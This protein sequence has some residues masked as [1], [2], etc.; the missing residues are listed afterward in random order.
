M[1]SESKF[2]G[3]LAYDE[4]SVAGNM[5]WGVFE[6]KPFTED[7]VDIEIT[8]SGICGSDIHTLRSGWG[9]TMYPCVVGHE[10][11]G[12]AV[13]VGSKAQQERGIK[14]GDRVGVGA[15]SGSCLK[16]ECAMCSSNEEPRCLHRVDTY[17]SIYPDGSKSYGGYANYNR[18]PGHFVVKIP[19]E[20][21]SADA[22]PMLCGGITVYSPLKKNGCGSTA[23][24]I[25]IVGIGGL[26]HFGLLFAKALG[27]EKITAIS[28]TSSKRAD[29]EKMGADVFIAT[30]EDHNWT[31][32]HS[33]SLD[34][35][36]STV[37]S[38]DM[39]LSGYLR[40]LKLNGRFVQVGAPEDFLPGFSAF[41]LIVHGVNISGSLIGS[42]SEIEEMLQL[43]AAKRIKPWIQKIPM[44]S[45]NK[46][47]VDMA[48]GKARYRYTL[49]N[50]N[51]TSDEA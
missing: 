1:A 11:V 14:V 39:P 44:K 32:K 49:V 45:A 18:S 35:I 9:P 2:V 6:P 3:W 5:K 19:D 27:A 21:D 34:L 42:P 4:S 23:K 51:A 47:V 48:H 16:P 20:L 7:D 29:A 30:N 38:S 8:H 41:S 46:A 43:A 40:L 28:R 33:N 37:S 50:D 15:Q 24:T 22:A 10:I 17:N 13:R 25:G 26:G 12:K 31:E 36:I